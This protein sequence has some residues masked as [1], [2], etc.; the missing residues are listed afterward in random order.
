[1]TSERPTGYEDV[2]VVILNRN[3]AKKCYN[4]IMPDGQRKL[5]PERKLV[6]VLGDQNAQT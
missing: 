1:V 2:T 3:A 6:P 4:V 5:L